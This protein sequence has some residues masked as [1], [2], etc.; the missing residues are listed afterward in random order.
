[1]LE[2]SLPPVNVPATFLTLSPVYS[3][4]T[5]RT[6]RGETLVVGGRLSTGKKFGE[7]KAGDCR[8]CGGCNTDAGG[9][10]SPG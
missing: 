6:V 7:E 2:K 3:F 1:M 5:H 9:R 10:S 8:A 4:R